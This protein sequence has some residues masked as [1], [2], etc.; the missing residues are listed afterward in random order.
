MS[1]QIEILTLDAKNV[2]FSEKSFW[3][4]WKIRFLTIL[5]ISY[6]NLHN[7][8][9]KPLWCWYHL[10]KNLVRRFFSKSVVVGWKTVTRI[11]IQK[12]GYKSRDIIPMTFS[13]RY[14][15]SHLINTYFHLF[16]RSFEISTFSTKNFDENFT[17]K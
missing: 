5:R 2:N 15:E 12:I 4:I 6:K 11:K 13:S 9:R 14:S 1:Q 8:S 3:K 17:K 7:F 16:Y 10:D